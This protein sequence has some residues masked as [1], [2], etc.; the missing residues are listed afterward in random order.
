[1]KLTKEKGVLLVL[2]FCLIVGVNV[3]IQKIAIQYSSPQFFSAVYFSLTAIPFTL[4]F[5]TKGKGSLKDIALSGKAI[6]VMGIFYGLNIF[7][8]TKAISTG[9]V[10]FVTIIISLS[11]LLTIVF[12]G[13]LLKEKGLVQRFLA[14]LIMVVGAALIALNP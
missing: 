4:L 2:L 1:M 12:S 6:I 8:G 7:A 14:G 13:A 9:K 10:T 11:I 3:P 5:L